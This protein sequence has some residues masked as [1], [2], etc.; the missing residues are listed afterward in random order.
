MPSRPRSLCD[1]NPSQI[2]VTSE[3]YAPKLVGTW[4]PGHSSDI[5]V[6]NPEAVSESSDPL[7]QK[8]GVEVGSE[9]SFGGGRTAVIHPN[10]PRGRSVGYRPTKY[11]SYGSN[12]QP[13]RA[14]VALPTVGRM[15]E[16]RFQANGSATG[17]C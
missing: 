4:A 17:R 3:Y 14:Q 2:R 7:A 11:S 6:T 8:L 5:Y 15:F 1:E 16:V 13:R 12:S 9:G 10:G